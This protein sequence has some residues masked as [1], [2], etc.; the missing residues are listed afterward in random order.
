LRFDELRAGNKARKQSSKGAPGAVSPKAK[1]SALVKKEPRELGGLVRR[2][3]M[4]SASSVSGNSDWDDNGKLCLLKRYFS[5]AHA[6]CSFCVLFRLCAWIRLQLA[7][8]IDIPD[9]SGLVVSVSTKGRWHSVAYQPSIGPCVPATTLQQRN[10]C[11]APGLCA[12]VTAKSV[13]GHRPIVVLSDTAVF[14]EPDPLRVA[15]DE[16]RLD[17]DSGWALCDGGLAGPWR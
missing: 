9:P 3:S 14:G 8:N 15:V 6:C 10:I 7:R 4:S 2:S 1:T 5:F 13:D 11:A 17:G 16:Q 12:V